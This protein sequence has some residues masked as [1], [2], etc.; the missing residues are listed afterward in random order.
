MQ[1]VEKAWGRE[2]IFV[3]NEHYCGKLL[4]FDKAGG[5]GSMHFHMKKHETFYVQ[6][7]MFKISWIETIDAS[8]H[9]TVLKEGDVWTNEPG[10]PH[11]IQSLENDSVIY[12]VSTH[13]DPNDNYRVL[14]GDGQ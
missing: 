10:N 9:D 6:K 2:K 11:Q 3:N 4:V 8:L 1:I 13:D 14:P 7:G 5:R 12:E